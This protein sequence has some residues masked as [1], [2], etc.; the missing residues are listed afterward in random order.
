MY[1]RLVNQIAKKTMPT[2][3]AKMAQLRL[4]AL[5]RRTAAGTYGRGDSPGMPAP[6]ATA[7]CRPSISEVS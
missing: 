3:Q 5:A 7:A 1:S 2:I 4:R 6:Y